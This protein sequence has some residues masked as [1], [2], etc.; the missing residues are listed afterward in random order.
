MFISYFFGEDLSERI[1]FSGI[2]E[3]SSNHTLSILATTLNKSI[4]LSFQNLPAF[5]IS[6]ISSIDNQ[7]E[8]LSNYIYSDSLTYIVSGEIN[9]S[10][11]NE[12]IVSVFIE[13]IAS[14]EK[15]VFT[16]SFDTPNSVFTCTDRL[17]NLVISY[18]LPKKVVKEES[19]QSNRKNELKS[20]RT[21]FFQFNQDLIDSNNKQYSF[22]GKATYC[23]DRHGN[24]NAALL[25]PKKSYG[26][27]QTKKNLLPYNNFT[28]SVWVKLDDD[29][30]TEYGRI[31]DCMD[32][33]S[34]TGYTIVVASDRSSVNFSYFS[35]NKS[36]VTISST[37][38]LK[39]NQWYSVTVTFNNG[40][41]CI[42]LDGILQ[43]KKKTKD[44]IGKSSRYISIG[45]GYE[46]YPSFYLS[47][48]LDDLAIFNTALT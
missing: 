23:S 12:Y 38:S 35:N 29:E 4:L 48:C 33:S 27:L 19:Y 47:G 11:N 40:V 36:L 32:W 21:S 41:S 15:E 8:Y 24:S 10:L 22:K 3:K 28:I 37:E 1:L 17:S 43:E 25:V 16:D 26:I 9:E 5:S 45:N 46:G 31:I 42:Y 34:K 44:E 2:S 39:R 13:N 14:K 7:N 18:F 6:N 20:L 30:L